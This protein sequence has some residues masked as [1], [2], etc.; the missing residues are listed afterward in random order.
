MSEY[1]RAPATKMLD[2]H[3]AACGRP[4]VDAHSVETGMGPFCRTKYG[5]VVDNSLDDISQS[6]ANALIHRI[7]TKRCSREELKVN[8]ESLLSLGYEQLAIV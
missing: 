5:R 6:A 1:E 2:V 8:I 4:L 3:C 7:A